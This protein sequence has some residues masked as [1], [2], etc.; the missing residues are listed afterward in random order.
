MLYVVFDFMYFVNENETQVNTSMLNT[1]Y[2][3]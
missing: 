2:K 1:G 3:S